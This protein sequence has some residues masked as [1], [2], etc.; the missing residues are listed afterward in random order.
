[1]KNLN[2]ARVVDFPFP[3]P[4]EIEVLKAAEERLQRLGALDPKSGCIT[5]LGRTMALFPVSP[6][7]AKMLGC[8]LRICIIF[9][10]I[11]GFYSPRKPVEHHALC[12]LHGCSLVGSGT[13]DKSDQFDTGKWWWNPECW[14]R[15]QKP[16]GNSENLGR[17]G[18]NLS[19]GGSECFIGYFKLYSTGFI[20]KQTWNIKGAVLEG[21]KQNF[22]EDFCQKTGF[23]PKAAQEIRKMRRQLTNLINLNFPNASLALDPKLDMPDQ[24]QACALRQ[25]VLSGLAWNVARKEPE[26]VGGFEGKTCI[27]VVFQ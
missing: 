1:M 15:D 25:I 3:T 11:V 16:P 9:G 2:I 27:L 19:S 21:E 4:P 13:H 17:S 18:R 23:R 7:Y 10:K 8:V 22:R 5:D 20:I 12:G 24:H 26:N 14:S 6:A